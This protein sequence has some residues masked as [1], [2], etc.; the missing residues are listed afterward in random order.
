MHI[1]RY[2]R[3]W[4]A[5]AAALVLFFFI[6]TAIILWHGVAYIPRGAKYASTRQH[7]ATPGV[8]KT[9]PGAYRVEM[10]GQMWLW[11]PKEIDVPAGATVTFD[12]TSNDVLHGFQVEGT[13][14]NLTAV[15]GEI[16]TVSHTFDRPG[17]YAIIC[18]EYCG[19]GHGLMEGKVVVE[20]GA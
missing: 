18:N 12:V 7:V 16:A 11:T 13:T 2:E 3:F 4:M 10:I 5:I 14:V 9:G 8:T 20:G 1:P 6:A 15:P 19:L 17:A